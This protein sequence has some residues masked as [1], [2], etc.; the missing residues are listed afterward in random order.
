MFY[1]TPLIMWEHYIFNDMTR[2]IIN[3]N[4][5]VVNSRP[6]AYLFIKSLPFVVLPD[7]IDFCVVILYVIPLI[8]V[9]LYYM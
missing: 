1:A 4:L 2:I 6:S 5:P 7:T 8:C 3:I 9:W